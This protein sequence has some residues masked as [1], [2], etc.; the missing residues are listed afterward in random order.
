[1]KK[2]IILDRDGVINYDSDNFIKSLDEFQFLSGSIDA[3]VR[4]KQAGYVVVI[5][6][7]QSGIARGYFP[8]STLQDMHD[9]LA[10]ALAGWG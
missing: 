7:N 9:K 3:I 1:M 4:L 2:L 8:L 10:G 6:T 5:A